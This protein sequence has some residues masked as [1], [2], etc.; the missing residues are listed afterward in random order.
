MSRKFA[1]STLMIVLL[2]VMSMIFVACDDKEPVM[3]TATFQGGNG[4]TGAQP[5]DVTVEVG[6]EITLPQNPYQKDGYNFVGWSDGASTYSVGDLYALLDNTTFTAVWEEKSYVLSYQGGEGVTGNAPTSHVEKAGTTI[7]LQSNTFEK[8]GF[9]F[10]GWL[11]GDTTYQA[12]DTYQTKASDE[13]AVAKW[14][15][16]PPPTYAITYVGGD[17]AVGDAPIE[18]AKVAGAQFE[19]KANTFNKTGY[20]FKGWNDGVSTYQAGTIYTMGESA[21]TLTAQWARIYSVTYV[22]GEGATGVAPIEEDKECYGQ[23]VLKE[24]TFT[25]EGYVFKGWSDGVMT[26]ASGFHYTMGTSNLT[27]TAVWA[28]TYTLTFDA[29]GAMGENPQAITVEA[30]TSVQYPQ[31]PYTMTGYEFLGW[32]L[33]AIKQLKN[34]GANLTVNANGT[35]KPI[36][37]SSYDGE[38][39]QMVLWANSTVAFLDGDEC[40]YT[41]SG[42]VVTLDFGGSVEEYSLLNSTYT[43]LDGMQNISFTA[44]DGTTLTFDGKGGMMLGETSGAY[45]WNDEG[46][47]QLSINEKVYK[48]VI[49]DGEGYHTNITIEGHVFGEGSTKY[50]VTYVFVADSEYDVYTGTAPIE[51]AKVPNEDFV[52]A[53]NTFDYPGFTF[54]GWSDGQGGSYFEGYIYTMGEA[55]VTFE[56]LWTSNGSHW[57]INYD[58]GEGAVG[59]APLQGSKPTGAIIKLQE[60]TFTKTGYVFAGWSDG[61]NVYQAGEQY[62]I[63]EGS[64]VLTAQWLKVCSITY[65]GGDG[66]TGTTP[67]QSDKLEG[68]TF[69]VATNSFEKYGYTFEGWSDGV[70]TYDEGDVYT[71]GNQ[72]VT[73]SAVWQ[74]ITYT[75]TYVGGEGAVGT[76]PIENE[77]S[78][79]VKFE[80]A[81]NTFEKTD[82]RFVGWSDGTSVYE[83]GDEYT[84]GAND[85]TFTAVWVEIEYATVSFDLNADGDVTNPDAIS[86]QKIEVGNCATKPTNPIREGYAFKGW[87]LDGADYDFESQVEE[88]ITLIAKWVKLYTVTYVSNGAD[89]TP[90]QTADVEEGATIQY[91]TNTLSMTGYAFLGWQ[92]GDSKLLKA[93]GES[94]VVNQNCTIKAVFGN[95]YGGSYGNLTLWAN[96]E[97]AFVA[98]DEYSYSILGEIYSILNGDVT[99]FTCKLDGSSYVVADIMQKYTFTANDGTTLIFDGFGNAMLGDTV[100]TYQVTSNTTFNIRVNEVLYAITIEK[101][102]DNTVVNAII[103]GHVFGKGEKI[104]LTATFT[105]GEGVTGDTPS[106]IIDK[107]YADDGITFTLPDGEGLAKD[108]YTFAGWTVEGGD[109]TVLTGEQTIKVDTNYISA[110]TEVESGDDGIIRETVEESLWTIDGE[111]MISPKE[112]AIFSGEVVI[113][114]YIGE[115]QVKGI[116]GGTTSTDSISPFF[117]N[118]TVTKVVLPEG[119]TTIEAYAFAHSTTT[120]STSVLKEINIP[121][122]VTA[123]G[124]NAFANLEALEID[125]VIPSG[126]TRIEDYTFQN[127]AK[128]KSLTL[129][130]NVTYIGSSAFNGCTGLNFTSI[131]L[132][133][134]LETIKGSAFKSISYL[135]VY[136]YADF[137][138]LSNNGSAHSSGMFDSTA[139]LYVASQHLTAMQESTYWTRYATQIKEMPT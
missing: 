95:V 44:T 39:G 41:Q 84:M 48:L 59:D 76:A 137:S 127:C 118:T 74:Q 47:Y 60:N 87:Q 8:E 64:V 78:E 65:V 107:C 91:A 25:K 96:S 52:L 132:P 61:E 112:D 75:V 66:T 99:V 15:L 101:D 100:A 115:T 49:E 56:A 88:S 26:L 139:N 34:E 13:V 85:V 38:Y 97:L 57:L 108:G 30:G 63:G 136:M 133:A 72:D 37:G 46:Y 106:A 105:L 130:D 113:P 134:N 32:Q 90:P 82:C 125:V 123:I 102:G 7:T 109:S 94:F 33:G 6:A 128:I 20:V 45:Q 19:L 62:T 10:A 16:I 77:K 138:Q 116:K 104:T 12:G 22:G 17:D 117:K 36:F 70:N 111:G 135:D 110:W 114:H 73:L 29:N 14:T 1:I 40:V 28:K 27:F 35:I 81:Q 93:E 67:I 120:G 31:N 79:G 53:Q 92:V 129:H 98:D 11:I 3:A 126:V 86:S 83:V 21:V 5:T 2:L 80:I 9:N 54:V 124:K 121:S 18:E 23:F 43:A 24:N 69:R 71:V 119:L 122:T 89:G 51:S 131:T 42:S 58:G 4:V 103:D 68:E 55:D 50:N